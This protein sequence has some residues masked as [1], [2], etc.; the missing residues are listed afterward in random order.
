MS[1][2]NDLIFALVEDSRTKELALISVHIMTIIFPEDL[3]VGKNLLK[4]AIGKFE[5]ECASGVAILGSIINGKPMFMISITEDVVARNLHAGDLAKVVANILGGSGGGKAT[6]AQGGGKSE[7]ADL[8]PI[9]INYS[10]V[11]VAENLR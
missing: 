7:R 9:A 4:G 10:K 1:G 2:K 6:F 3:G 5:N 8:L 11:Y